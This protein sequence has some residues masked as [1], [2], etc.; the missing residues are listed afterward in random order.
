MA[1]PAD[2]PGLSGSVSGHPGQWPEEGSVPLPGARVGAAGCGLGGP[3]A[4]GREG[5]GRCPGQGMC[6]GMAGGY[7]GERWRGQRKG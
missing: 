5:A 6:V 3:L 2:G 7:P 4:V 1:G